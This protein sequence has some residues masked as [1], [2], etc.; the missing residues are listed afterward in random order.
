[1]AAINSTARPAYVYDEGTN[2]W[3]RIAGDVNTASAYTWT[4]AQTFDSPVTL[5]S[6]TI[7]KN[8][9]IFLNPSAVTAAIPSPVYGT[10]IF[11]KQDSVGNTI[12]DLQVYDGSTWQSITDPV[13]TFNQQSSSYTLAIADSFKM[14][15]MSAG[16]TVTVPLNSSV[17]F[18]I[19]TAIDIWNDED[20]EKKCLENF[21]KAGMLERIRI[22]KGDSTDGLI[23]L[24]KEDE[25]F[26]FI[27]VDGSHTLCDTY[28]DCL[29]ALKLLKKDG[30]M[31]IDD[32]LMA[33]DE[34]DR[35]DI[36]YLPREGVIQFINKYS[37]KIKAL[38][39]DYRLFLQKLEE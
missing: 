8:F 32:V 11:I 25:K 15:E 18:P 20:V 24:I 19:G 12:N 34:E 31:G 30:I 35:K 2:Q 28:S 36:I 38:D 13:Y 23:D 22:M 21:K 10:L 9:N 33:K 4:A 14:V 6:T 5:S 27:Y 29:L 39:N 1:M 16:G 17:A 7:S 37:N 26:D 3:Y